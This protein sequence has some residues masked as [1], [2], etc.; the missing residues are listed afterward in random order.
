MEEI[1]QLHQ[2]TIEHFNER[3][4]RIYAG[5]VAKGYGYG[6]ITKVAQE[7]GMDV[8]TVARGIK[9]LSEEPPYWQSEETGRGKEKEE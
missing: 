1:V 5:S 2:Q 6:G 9:E 8:H 3:Q 4:K 7:V